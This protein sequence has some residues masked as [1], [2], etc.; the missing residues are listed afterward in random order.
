VENEYALLALV[1]NIIIPPQKWGVRKII[2]IKA[3][4]PTPTPTPTIKAT[5]E[6]PL[7]LSL[8]VPWRLSTLTG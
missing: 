6:L 3:P 5:P 7:E 8:L 1:R 4:A 2:T